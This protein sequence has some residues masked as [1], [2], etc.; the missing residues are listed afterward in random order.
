M[1]LRIGVA[2]NRRFTDSVTLALALPLR[3]TS[4]MS[5]SVPFAVDM[6][7]VATPLPPDVGYSVTA[8][9]PGT[10]NDAKGVGGLAGPPRP[11]PRPSVCAAAATAAVVL[12]EAC[13]FWS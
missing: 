1:S 13:A 6:L 5:F 9:V 4:S 10:G 2:Y 8:S 12:I 7:S 3:A 11:R